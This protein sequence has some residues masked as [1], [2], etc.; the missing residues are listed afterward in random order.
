VLARIQIRTALPRERALRERED[1]GSV[2]VRS[3]ATHTRGGAMRMG[4][5]SRSLP[6]RIGCGIDTHRCSQGQ[7]LLAEPECS[8]GRRC[9]S[10]VSAPRS[11][12]CDVLGTGTYARFGDLHALSRCTRAVG[13][14]H[15]WKVWVGVCRGLP[16]HQ[17]RRRVLGVVARVAPLGSGSAPRRCVSWRA[18]GTEGVVYSF[19]PWDPALS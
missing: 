6:R 8:S 2:M 14:P 9:V 4:P 16:P 13:R 17:L 5:C 15:A 1:G 19:T 10:T 3:F 18:L 7:M 11:I 12:G